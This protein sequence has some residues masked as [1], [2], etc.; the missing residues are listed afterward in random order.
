MGNLRLFGSSKLD[1]LFQGFL[2]S[3]I[4]FSGMRTSREEDNKSIY[5]ED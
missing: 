2:S 1:Q 4:G 3:E 5:T